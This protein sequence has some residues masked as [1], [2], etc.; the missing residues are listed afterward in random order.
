MGLLLPAGKRKKDENMELLLGKSLLIFSLEA[1]GQAND[2][3][4]HFITKNTQKR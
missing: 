4:H 3:K 2:E 1:Y